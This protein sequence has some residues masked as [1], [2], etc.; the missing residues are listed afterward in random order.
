MYGQKK[1]EKDSYQQCVFIMKGLFSLIIFS[2]PAREC[3]QYCCYLNSKGRTLLSVN[4]L[5]SLGNC[6]HFASKLTDSCKRALH[7][8]PYSRGYFID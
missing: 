2:L 1:T 3:S 7:A 8:F 4:L 6:V 5:V